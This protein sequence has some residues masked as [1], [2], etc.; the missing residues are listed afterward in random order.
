MVILKAIAVMDNLKIVLE[1]VGILLNDNLFAI[2]IGQFT[3]I[4]F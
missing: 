3:L 4:Y 1:N 2:N